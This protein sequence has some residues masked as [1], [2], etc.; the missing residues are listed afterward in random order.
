MAGAPSGE[1]AWER[2]LELVL[3]HAGFNT[4][5]RVTIAAPGGRTTQVRIAGRDL[6]ANPLLAERLVVWVRAHQERVVKAAH[7]DRRVVISALEEAPEGLTF[8][9]VGLFPD[10]LP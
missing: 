1:V 3:H 9:L 6:A 10:L 7:V 8:I 2:F 5:V 4:P